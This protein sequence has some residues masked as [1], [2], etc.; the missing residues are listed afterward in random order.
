M[1]LFIVQI[2]LVKIWRGFFFDMDNTI[3]LKQRK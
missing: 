2:N 3:A 1:N